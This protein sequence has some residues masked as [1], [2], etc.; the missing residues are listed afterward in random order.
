MIVAT[1]SDSTHTCYLVIPSS[2]KAVAGLT[3]LERLSL[4]TVVDPEFRMRLFYSPNPLLREWNVDPDGHISKVLNE[5]R[6]LQLL[7]EDPDAFL[8]WIP[9][10]RAPGLQRACRRPQDD[11]LHIT[12]AN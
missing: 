5:P 1:I 3:E 9:D 11:P 2:D 10:E 4:D 7:F 8:L 6:E 12:T